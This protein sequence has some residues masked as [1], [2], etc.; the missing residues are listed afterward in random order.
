MR[1][2]IPAT[3]RLRDFRRFW[4]GESVSMLGD[5]VTVVALPLTAVL[6]LDATPAEMGYLT[7]AALIPNLIFSLHA[8]AWVDR[9]A[10]QRRTMIAADI[11]RGLLLATI[12]IAYAFDALTIEQMYVVGFL[13]GVFSVL[14]FVAY[15]T[16]FTNLVEREHY[17]E[18]N[19]LTNGSRAATFV[20]GPSIAGLLVQAISGPLTLAVDAVSFLVSA[21]FLGTI[22]P[23]Q[24]EPTEHDQG[25]VMVGARFI[26]GD[27]MLRTMLMSVA[28]INLFNFA[29][30]AIYFLFVTHE[31]HISAGA[32]GLVLGAAAIGSLIGSVI[33]GPLTRRFGIGPVY[34]LG[35]LLFPLPLV[36]VPL[37]SGPRPV[38]FAMLF[39]SEFISGVGLMMLDIN[40]AAMYQAAVPER[41][42]SRFFGAFLTVNYGVRPIG[43][44]AGGLLGEALGLRSALWIA[45]V[46]ALVGILILLPTQVPRMRDLP[47]QRA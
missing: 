25:S 27:S 30:W 31:L 15:N 1:L 9:R 12:P 13:S 29:F 23:R 36:L 5:Q 47:E 35:V 11:G 7:A 34:T 3:L 40:G 8:G 4:I 19:S 37:A 14:F 33:T 41:L 24:P 46:G 10:N 43:S 42:L 38:I 2:R 17:V 22:H 32:I 26:A 21:C 16:V 45:S 18:A 28:V 6:V 44:V 39:A 20:V